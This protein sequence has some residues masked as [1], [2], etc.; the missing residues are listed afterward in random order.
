MEEANILCRNGHRMEFLNAGLI[1]DNKNNNQ[2]FDACYRCLECDQYKV[3]RYVPTVCVRSY[4]SF[5]EL[6]ENDRPCMDN[7]FVIA[8]VKDIARFRHYVVGKHNCDSTIA[9][10]RGRA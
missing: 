9:V 2:F 6:I 8:L 4:N 10:E 5:E 7:R 1:G 3:L